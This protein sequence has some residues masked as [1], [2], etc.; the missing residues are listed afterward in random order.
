MT[1]QVIRHA[2][3]AWIDITNPIIKDITYLKDN[4]SFHPLDLEDCLSH[5][6]R[7]KIDEYDDYL[8]IVMQFPK[9]DYTRRISRPSKVAF[10][11]GKGY[12]VT[13]HDD[14]LKPLD[15]FFDE[16]YHLE[17]VRQRYME[18]GASVLLHAVI[19]RLIDYLFPIIKK[20]EQQITEIEKDIF[21]DDMQTIVQEI[22]MARRDIIALRRI[23]RPQVNIIANLEREDRSFIHDELDVY[24]SDILDHIIHVR[25]M[26]DEDY[27][28]MADL[29]EATDSLISYRINE[30]MRTLTVISITML[31][32]TLISGIYGM[33]VSLPL[34]QKSY[35]FLIIAVMMISILILMLIF[36]HRRRWL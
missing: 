36:F 5:L 13:V 17:S 4:Y 8:F 14:V 3:V 16:C 28:I 6:E 22:S 30:V 15:K 35:A 25:D 2:N 1:L 10:F 33:N 34:A 32:M 23:I 19:D 20:I 7:P 18:R 9:F 29:S 21:I 12:L 27:E 31:P 11:I 26:L 24:F